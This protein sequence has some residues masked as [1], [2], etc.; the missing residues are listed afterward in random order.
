MAHER[1]FPHGG[2]TLVDLMSDWRS[3]AAEAAALP[4][5]S[6]EWRQASDVAHY[7]RA[8]LDERLEVTAR[9]QRAFRLR[10]RRP[11]DH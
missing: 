6:P 9:A 1:S 4:A 8:L 7:R 2:V 11:R 3:A 10:H 5:D